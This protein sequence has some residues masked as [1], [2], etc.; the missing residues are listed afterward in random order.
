MTVIGAMP[1]QQVAAEAEIGAR[2]L[3]MLLDGRREPGEK[4]LS[5]RTAPSAHVALIRIGIVEGGAHFG[6]GGLSVGG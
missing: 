6:H 3:R 4:F 5:D 1:R 2:H